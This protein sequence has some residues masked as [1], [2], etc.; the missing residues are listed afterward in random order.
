M[1]QFII[2]CLLG[3]LSINS[4]AVYAQKKETK[5]E[6]TDEQKAVAV[7]INPLAAQLENYD[8]LRQHEDTLQQMLKK[9]VDAKRFDDKK[10]YCYKFIPKLIAALKVKG[11]SQYPFDSL[12]IIS[13][14]TP[15]DKKF[16]IF[17]WM[18]EEIDTVGNS[19]VTSYRYYGAI[20]MN[21]DEEFQLYG[22]V[23]KSTETSSPEAKELPPNEWFG[24]LYYNLVQKR[25][26]KGKT[27]YTLFGWDGNNERSTK[28]VADV[29]HFKKDGKPVFGAPI[30]DIVRDGK[31]FVGNRFI[32]EF[33]EGSNVGL[34][35]HKD[36]NIIIYDFLKPEKKETEGE[37]ST[38]V[39]DGT[40]HGFQF[41]GDMWK[42]V[43]KIFTTTLP[44][45]PR[46]KPVLNSDNKRKKKKRKNKKKKK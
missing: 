14:L 41:K 29:L 18:L 23:D 33:K 44:T 43:P 17:T 35:F 22:L 38:Y 11:S 28:K 16:R 46:P 7:D 21:N 12:K 6:K 5:T 13:M 42:Y 34:N 32:M 9:M 37:F 8:V 25:T 30:F 1:K 20:H 4:V 40:Y 45:A 19:L 15:T 27:Y 26:P 31:R 10:A 39:P 2:L 24:A 3:L 36:K